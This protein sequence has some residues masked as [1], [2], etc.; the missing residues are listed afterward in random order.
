MPLNQELQQFKETE[1]GETFSLQNDRLLK[2]E[3][4]GVTV[5]AKA[6]SMVA[7]QG[8]VKFEHAGSGGMGRLLK[9]MATGEGV[10][11]MKASGTGEVFLAE[12]AQEIHLVK[13]D[14]DSI[15]V[16]GRNCWPST[17]ASTGTSRRSREGRG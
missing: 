4:A 14:D 9:K 8:E 7:Y 6:G 1:T 10:T 16:N 15:T 3:L 5:Q 12:Y 11:L 2:V 13:L 17:P